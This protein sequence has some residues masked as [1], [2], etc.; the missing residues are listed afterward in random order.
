[1]SKVHKSLTR[2]LHQ[3]APAEA[4]RR[5]VENALTTLG[6]QLQRSESSHYHW[7]HPD[8]TQITYALVNGRTVKRVV[9]KAIAKEIR[10]RGL[11]N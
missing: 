3:P 1:M 11:G 7:E 8:G 5:E 6:F 10:R 9:V 4:T 2:F